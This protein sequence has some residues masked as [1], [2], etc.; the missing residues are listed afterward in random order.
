E[1]ISFLNKASDLHGPFHDDY[2]IMLAYCGDPEGLDQARQIARTKSLEAE[3]RV[4]AFEAL[5]YREPPSSI[6]PL[7]AKLLAEADSADSTAFR[8]KVLDSLDS[9]DDP[10]LAPIVLEAFASLPAQSKPR[11]I[12]LLTRR[13]VWAKALLDAIV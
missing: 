3:S 10:E 2:S 5:L 13:P 6:R 9:I 1:L 12:E 11:A 7:V 8:G 4:R